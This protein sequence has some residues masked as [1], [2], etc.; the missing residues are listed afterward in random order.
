MDTLGDL[1]CAD[2]LVT[3]DRI[4]QIATKINADDALLVDA[5]GC[6]MIPG[7]VN[8]HMHTWQTA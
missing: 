3:E 6:I 1:P 5:G 8:A 7:L 4:T 2:V